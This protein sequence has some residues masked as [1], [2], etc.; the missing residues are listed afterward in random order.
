MKTMLIAAAAV[1]VATVVGF[2]LF[3]VWQAVTGH[4]R[5]AQASADVAAQSKEIASAAA[6]GHDAVEAVSNQADEESTTADLTKANADAIHAAPG[7]EAPVTPDADNAGLRA[8]C[9]RHVYRN[10]P[11]CRQLRHPGS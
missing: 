1:V 10:D 9:L 6:A 3:L 11:A 2:G 5:Q 7:A 4:Q 8:L